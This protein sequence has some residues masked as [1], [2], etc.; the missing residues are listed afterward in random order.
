MPSSPTRSP[1]QAHIKLQLCGSGSIKRIH[2]MYPSHVI[3]SINSVQAC[4]KQV[5]WGIVLVCW[6]FFSLNEK[7]FI[8][9][10][11][12]VLKKLHI[13]NITVQCYGY[14]RQSKKGCVLFWFQVKWLGMVFTTFHQ[15]MSEAL[16]TT[17]RTNMTHIKTVSTV[18]NQRVAQG[19]IFRNQRWPT[20]F[21]YYFRRAKWKKK[22]PNPKTQ[23][24]ITQTTVSYYNAPSSLW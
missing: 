17:I 4:W 2:H 16:Y 10:M 12:E 9:L 6:V 7:S 21:C 24:K 14:K 5:T 11:F 22:N 13:N 18:T 20:E 15:K 19:H 1:Q 8:L 23:N 3:Y